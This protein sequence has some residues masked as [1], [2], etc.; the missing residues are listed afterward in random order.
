LLALSYKYGKA[1]NSIMGKYK[2]E[3]KSMLGNIVGE[4]LAKD[5]FEA[6]FPEPIEG[7]LPGSILTL[8]ELRALPD[9]TVIHI[10]YI[11]EDGNE[12]EDGFQKLSKYSDDEWSAGAFPFPIDEIKEDELIDRCDN[13]GWTFTI[14]M[15]VPGK[16]GEYAAIQKKKRT[17]LKNLDKLQELYRK[18]Q[19]TTDKVKKKELKKK[20]NE[21]AKIVQKSL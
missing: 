13:S 5:I 17:T 10:H 7:Y 15:A 4:D 8:A 11:D 16:K 12:R 14:R 6:N 3:I 1:N 21:L 19:H 2:K 20:Y 9:G 18:I